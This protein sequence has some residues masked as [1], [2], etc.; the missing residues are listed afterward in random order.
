MLIYP[1]FL[2]D[3]DDA[4]EVISSLPG[5]KRWGMN[6]LEG[7]LR[8][9]VEKGLKSVILFGVPVKMTKDPRG[10]PADDPS[11]PVIRGLKLL[12]KLFPQLLLCVDVCLCEYTSTGQCGI[13]SSHA[14]PA[15]SNLPTLDAEASAQRIAEVALAYAKAGAHVVAPSDMMDG[16]IRSIKLALMSEG[17]A[18]RCTLMSYSAKF[19]S[20]LYG[21]FR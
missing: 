8:P 17:L 15:H 6:K 2:S 21:P 18:N 12:T 3:D 16:R 10:S 20:G 11:T 4:E 1:I 7:F 9:L 13:L 19:A 14:N 5:Q